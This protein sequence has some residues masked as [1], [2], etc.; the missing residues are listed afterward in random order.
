[1]SEV[2]EASPVTT[3]RKPARV[4]ATT[5]AALRAA[6][7]RRAGTAAPGWKATNGSSPISEASR[8]GSGPTGRMRRAPSSSTGKRHPAAS[9][10]DSAR[11]AS[12]IPLG[13]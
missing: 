1:V 13:T 3:T 9:T 8:S 4:N 7:G 12:A 6:V 11:F 5:M 10:S 2:S